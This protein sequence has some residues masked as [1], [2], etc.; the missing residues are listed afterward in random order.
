MKPFVG[1]PSDTADGCAYAA[2]LDAPP[3]TQAATVH[4]IGRAPGWGWVALPSCD[5]HQAIAEAGCA[6]VADVHPA[7][8]CSGE[9][10]APMR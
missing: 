1:L 6:D 10:Y 7:A 3:C 8:G 2:D 9:H 5:D 4:I